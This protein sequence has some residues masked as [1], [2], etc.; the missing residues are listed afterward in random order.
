MT[1][2]YNCKICRLM[3]TSKVKM[4][5]VFLNRLIT[6]SPAALS[7]SDFLNW[8]SGTAAAGMERRGPGNAGEIEPAHSG[9]ESVVMVQCCLQ[10][11]QSK[12][13]W[14][15]QWDQC[16]ESRPRRRQRLLS[17]RL[18]RWRWCWQAEE[19]PGRGAGRRHRNRKI[20]L[21]SQ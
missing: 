21:Y 15:R 6:L 10:C 20:I 16:R 11:H 8:I 2:Y 4:P 18:D 17:S 9:A 12:L 3:L 5:E 13:L 1:W 19:R 14:W 7:M